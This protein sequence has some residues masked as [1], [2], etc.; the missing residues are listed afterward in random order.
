MNND[1]IE[2]AIA[3]LEQSAGPFDEACM[4][5]R[6]AA[7]SIPADGGEQAVA[8][9]AKP[10]E[11][12]KSGP[13]PDGTTQ[14]AEGDYGFHIYHDPRS[15]DEG[16]EYRAAWGEGDSEYFGTLEEAQAWC[17]KE[18]DEWIALYTRPS[19]AANIQ[20]RDTDW[21][22]AMAEALGTDSGYSVPIVPTA[23]AFRELFS[24]IRSTPP[25][26]EQSGE[27][28]T[29]PD[30]PERIWLNL[31]DCTAEEIASNNAGWNGLTDVT[32]SSS[33]M[34]QFDIPYIRA[35][36]ATS[37][38]KPTDS[39]GQAVVKYVGVSD[40]DAPQPYDSHP[41]DNEPRCEKLR[42]RF[43]VMGDDVGQGLHPYWKWAFAAGYNA[44]KDDYN[45][46]L[47]VGAMAMRAAE[48]CNETKRDMDEQAQ[49]ITDFTYADAIEEV[50][51]RLRALT[52]DAAKEALEQVCMEVADALHEA[53]P[54]EETLLESVRRKLVR[55]VLSNKLDKSGIE[56]GE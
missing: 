39:E 6:K 1:K 47:L 25:Q 46:D 2:R 56:G 54:A 41:N 45:A 53:W 44:A 15:E 33:K 36:L 31:G 20:A 4:L 50:Y 10:I 29:Y 12:E 40:K 13:F 51:A 19:P 30:A 38:V 3:L 42:H 21:V 18:I 5:L 23:D 27:A 28:V 22:L 11:W 17:Q 49:S 43:K 35:D 24:A 48:V 14:W 7:L 32:W 8:V 16:Y 26:Q 9:R 37:P 34:D 52:P 55:Q